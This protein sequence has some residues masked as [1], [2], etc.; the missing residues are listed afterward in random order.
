MLKKAV[1]ICL[2]GL[3]NSSFSATVKNIIL[4][5]FQPS[6]EGGGLF[7]ICYDPEDTGNQ[8]YCN[9]YGAPTPTAPGSSTYINSCEM[10]CSQGWVIL[11]QCRGSSQWTGV[12]GTPNSIVVPNGHF[13]LQGSETYGSNTDNFIGFTSI[14]DQ[15]NEIVY[16]ILGH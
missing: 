10:T 4:G 5:D 2:L 14:V 15:P 1:V 6:G 9:F 11:S 13:M 3:S 16:C 12:Y 7:S 8:A